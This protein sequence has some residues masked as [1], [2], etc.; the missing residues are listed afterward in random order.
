MKSIY[1]YSVVVPVGA[2]VLDSKVS[3]VLAPFLET[4]VG[5]E[6]RTRSTL[7]FCWK[8]GRYRT[9]RPNWP[10]LQACLIPF[11][12]ASWYLYNEAIRVKR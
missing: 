4:L 2:H 11:T 8:F 6:K 9:T 10:N 12:V 3:F 1:W 5:R 7:T